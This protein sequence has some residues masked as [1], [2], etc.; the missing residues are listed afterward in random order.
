VGG[1]GLVAA[2]HVNMGQRR[3]KKQT[4]A[5]GEGGIISKEMTISQPSVQKLIAAVADPRTGKATA[6]S[7]SRTVA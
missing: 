6:R 5:A 3:H 1:G 2:R 4:A 7:A